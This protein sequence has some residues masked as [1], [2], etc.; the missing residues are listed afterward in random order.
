MH[1]RLCVLVQAALEPLLS[2]DWALGL[3]KLRRYRRSLLFKLSRQRGMME[4]YVQLEVLEPHFN[5]VT[6]RQ[7]T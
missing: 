5:G 7:S 3:L 2:A 1:C 4:V 6:P